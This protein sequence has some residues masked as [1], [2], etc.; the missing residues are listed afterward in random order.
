MDDAR[1]SGGLWLVPTVA[2]A[3][4]V[5]LPNLAE[6]PAPLAREHEVD[7][8]RYGLALTQR[9]AFWKDLAANDQ[10]WRR[11]AQAAFP[12]DPW[13]QADHWTDLMA[14]Y[15][16]QQAARF[17]VSVV[18][19]LLAYDEGLHLGWKGPGGKPLRT[20]WPPLSTRPR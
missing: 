16:R 20:Q 10:R 5:A 1:R 9:R 13:A 2:L 3:I 18:Q 11:A 15:V 7:G 6:A 19:V 12:D 8:Q 4:A 17:D 14:Q